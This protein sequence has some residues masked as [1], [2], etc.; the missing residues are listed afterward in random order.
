M[1]RLDA[2]DPG[3]IAADYVTAAIG[4]DG[5]RVALVALRAGWLT[6]AEAERLE[7]LAAGLAQILDEPVPPHRPDGTARMRAARS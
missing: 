3:L 1:S 4:V 6:P 5:A 7:P 2:F